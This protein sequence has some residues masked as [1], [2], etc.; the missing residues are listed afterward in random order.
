MIRAQGVRYVGR[1]AI[2]A[3]HHEVE[4]ADPLFPQ[5]FR[6]IDQVNNWGGPNVDNEYLSAAVDPSH[7]YHVHADL[8]R[9]A[10]LL[11]QS[12]RGIWHL[13]EGFAVLDDWSIDDFKL[14]DDG[15]LDLYLGGPERSDVNWFPLHPEAERLW[16]RQYGTAW[17]EHRVGGF[18]ITRIDDGPLTP[19]VLT[20]EKIAE[21]VDNAAEW[22]AGA[23]R[24][25]PSSLLNRAHPLPVNSLP[26]PFVSSQGSAQISYAFTRLDLEGPQG[27]A[28]ELDEPDARYWSFQLYSFPWWESLDARNGLTSLNHDQLVADP[29]GRVRVVVSVEDPGCATGST[30]APR[31]GPC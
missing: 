20:N 22:L 12:I 7:A 19:A 3:L 18:S 5:W 9:S 1:A 6:C 23:V 14:N 29:D 15:T 26:K 25:W 21:Q 13:P 2:A 16:V 4:Y 8:S 10:G 30:A 27:L 31:R 28:I 24:H 17:D 11:L